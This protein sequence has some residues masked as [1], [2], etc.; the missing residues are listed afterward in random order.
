MVG[1]PWASLTAAVT[2]ILVVPS[3]TSR[4]ALKLMAVMLG[5]WLK[6]VG[7]RSTRWILARSPSG[8]LPIK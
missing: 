7:A 1:N 5:A 3:L 8:L 2:V 6:S 4:G